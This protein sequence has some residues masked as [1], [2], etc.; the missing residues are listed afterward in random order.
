MIDVKRYHRLKGQGLTKFAE[1]EDGKYLQFNRYDVETGCLIDPEEQRINMQ[2]INEAKARLQKEIDA[3]D[4]F[5]KD[6]PV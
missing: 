2:E 5:I 1:K 3:I 6:I 4:L